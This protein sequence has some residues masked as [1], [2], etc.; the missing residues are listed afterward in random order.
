MAIPWCTAGSAQVVRPAFDRVPRA[1]ERAA[2]RADPG[3]E[4]LFLGRDGDRV[5][6]R[7]GSEELLAVPETAV[8]PVHGDQARHPSRR[9]GIRPGPAP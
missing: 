1:D 8:F 3:T 6:V 5:V 7:D 9:V 4:P 2:H